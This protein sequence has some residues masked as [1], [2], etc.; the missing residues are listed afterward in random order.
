MKQEYKSQIYY[1]LKAF[2]VFLSVAILYLLIIG[3]IAVALGTPLIAGV[4]FGILCIVPWVF[5]KNFKEQFTKQAILEFDE[6]GFSITTCNLKDEKEVKKAIYYWKDIKSYKFYFTPSNLTYLDIYLRNG[7]RKEFG[8]KDDKTQE[9]STNVDNISIFNVFRSFV[10]K[11]NSD[12]ELDDNI[13]LRPGFLITRAGTN[14]ICFVGALMLAAVVLVIILNPKSF[15]FLFMGIF[16]F[17]PLIAKRRQDKILY[18]KLC[19]MG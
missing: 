2:V 4:G 5:Q 17:L 12:K 8:F 9:V 14:Y 11:Y 3:W 19:K 6:H 15:P 10:K 7:K 18:D 1:A 13:A 16:I